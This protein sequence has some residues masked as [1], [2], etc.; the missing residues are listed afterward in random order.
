MS[1]PLESEERWKNKTV[2]ACERNIRSSP[3]RKIHSLVVW[4]CE[5]IHLLLLPLLPLL[6]M[7]LLP[8]PLLLLM[9]LPL[10]L[11]MLLL[12][13]GNPSH[14]DLTNLMWC[15]TF[16]FPSEAYLTPIILRLSAIYLKWA[17]LELGLFVEAT[18]SSH[19][20]GMPRRLRQSSIIL[21]LK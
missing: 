11:M 16:H 3:N 8:L 12:F 5:P 10:L 17:Q 18:K 4:V 14:R 7:L 2:L 21:C 1:H 19:Y 6:P 9:L 13:L 15:L 20:L